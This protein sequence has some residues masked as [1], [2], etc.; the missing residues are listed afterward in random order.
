MHG[1]FSHAILIQESFCFCTDHDCVIMCRKLLHSG[2][3]DVSYFAAGII[4]HLASDGADTW[5]VEIVT[6]QQLLQELVSI[7]AV[8]AS[9]NL[10]TYPIHGYVMYSAEYLLSP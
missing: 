2:H 6:R 8:T 1:T 3:I 7:L 4:A 10:F 5:T 9:K